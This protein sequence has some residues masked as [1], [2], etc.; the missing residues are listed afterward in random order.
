MDDHQENNKNLQPI[1]RYL[2]MASATEE[3]IDAFID[4]LLDEADEDVVDPDTV[5]RKILRYHG[6]DPSQSVHYWTQKASTGDREGVLAVVE[7]QSSEWH[8]V[9]HCPC[10]PLSW[11]SGCSNPT[12]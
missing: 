4:A 7:C 9:I 8:A 2:H 10:S 1:K 5:I 12:R 3:S 6:V 11:G